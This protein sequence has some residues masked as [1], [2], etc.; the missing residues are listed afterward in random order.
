MVRWCRPAA[1]RRTCADAVGRAAGPAVA[2]QLPAC[3]I[4]GGAKTARYC[5]AVGE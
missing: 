2:E 4:D 1:R 5:I 3:D